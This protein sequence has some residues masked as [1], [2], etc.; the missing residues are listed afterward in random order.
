MITLEWHISVIVCSDFVD[1]VCL[2]LCFISELFRLP[3]TEEGEGPISLSDPK[4]KDAL[5]LS[6]FSPQRLK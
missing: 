5:Q 2:E 6:L 4:P 1:L 3:I